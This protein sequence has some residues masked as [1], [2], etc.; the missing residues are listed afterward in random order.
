MTPCSGTLRKQ[1]GAL[2]GLN[3]CH[4][5]FLP[6]S[7][8]LK[9]HCHCLGGGPAP[10]LSDSVLGAQPH[11]N[12]IIQALKAPCTALSLPT[13]DPSRLGLREAGAPGLARLH[14]D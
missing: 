2:Q 9:R 1:V 14:L 11:S 3:L 5:K 13:P 7:W 8:G 10:L 6:S 4:S 12:F